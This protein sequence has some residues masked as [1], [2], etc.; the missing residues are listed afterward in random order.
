MEEMNM[1]KVNVVH[2]HP[3][4][5]VSITDHYRRRQHSN[6]H[7]YGGLYGYGSRMD[8]VVE[9]SDAMPSILQMSNSEIQKDKQLEHNWKRLTT[10]AYPMM[11]VVGWYTSQ[12]LNES[13]RLLKE[14]ISA[15]WMGD[16]EDSIS[17]F[18]G[19]NSNCSKENKTCIVIVLR[20]DLE[21]D[22]IRVEAYRYTD[23]NDYEKLTVCVEGSLQ[24]KVAVDILL[25]SKK[26][27]SADRNNSLYASS[28]TSL[29]QVRETLERM[30]FNVQE[31]VTYID[32]VINRRRRGDTHIA[33]QLANAIRSVPVVSAKAFDDMINS[34]INGQLMLLYIS[35]M[36]N[37]QLVMNEHV[38]LH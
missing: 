11:R 24:E 18:S 14:K 20:I 5:V 6:D 34:N 28:L 17:N 33:R 31:L 36:F 13:E 16:D 32:D 25:G 15:E 4:A 35:S 2:L 7:V 23:Y 21:I 8:G 26:I 1:E 19:H 9:V 10:L 12:P 3:L 22:D 29:E 30:Q 37:A 38:H 27:N